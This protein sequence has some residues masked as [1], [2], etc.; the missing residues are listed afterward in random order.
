M[1]VIEAH[2]AHVSAQ[3]T[4][5]ITKTSSYCCDQDHH[6]FDMF[7]QSYVST[8]ETLTHRNHDMAQM[9][10]GLLLVLSNLL[11]GASLHISAKYVSRTSRG[12]SHK[13]KETAPENA[14]L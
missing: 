5:G 2:N 12:G 7:V 11:I 14:K 8:S 10:I 3:Q 1:A 6:M 13:R 4:T 9:I